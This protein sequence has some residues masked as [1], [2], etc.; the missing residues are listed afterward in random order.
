MYD[1]QIYQPTFRRMIDSFQITRY[2]RGKITD[3]V[4][5]ERKVKIE[6]NR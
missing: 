5:K 1:F 6:E 2:A 4:N 3:L